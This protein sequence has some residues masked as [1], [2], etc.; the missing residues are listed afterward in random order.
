MNSGAHQEQ[1]ASR[2][3]VLHFA[4]LSPPCQANGVS[5]CHLHVSSACTLQRCVGLPP[6][7]LRMGLPND[8]PS[9]C[10]M[11]PCSERGRGGGETGHIAPE[12]PPASATTPRTNWKWKHPIP[13]PC[14]AFGGHITRWPRL[15]N[16]RCTNTCVT[17][18]A[19]AAGF[20]RHTASSWTVLAIY[21]IA[22][23]PIA[24]LNQLYCRVAVPC[25]TYWVDVEADQAGAHTALKHQ[26]D[27]A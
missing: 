25:E 15:T 19:V 14:W 4:T 8:Y 17:P 22:F 20:M 6:P 13:C 16:P 23:P 27:E 12:Q 3:R 21:M 10:I 11:P 7:P 1:N 2:Q 5:L 9:C 24:T 26:L 18:A